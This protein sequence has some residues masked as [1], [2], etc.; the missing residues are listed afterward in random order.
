MVPVERL[1][2]LLEQVLLLLLLGEGQ[3]VLVTVEFGFAAILQHHLRRGPAAAVPEVH[4]GAPCASARAE[5]QGVHDGAGHELND[6]WG[7]CVGGPGAARARG[8]SGRGAAA[9]GGGWGH[10]Q[11][12]HVLVQVM[13]AVRQLGE[14]L[15][16]LGGWAGVAWL[17]RGPLCRW[18]MGGGDRERCLSS[19]VGGCW[20]RG[21]APR[22]GRR[23]V[24]GVRRDAIY[25]SPSWFRRDEILLRTE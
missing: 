25:K 7:A 19:M 24:S 23:T 14:G 8:L 10:R 13:V 1:L 22:G 16:V 6:T 18:K 15:G 11:R 2:L 9:V 3:L 21:S 17:R 5:E 12:V 20:G 4:R